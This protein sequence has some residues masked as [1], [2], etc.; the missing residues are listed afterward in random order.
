MTTK[1][2]LRPAI[3]QAWLAIN[4]ELNLLSE[5]QMIQQKD[6]AGWCVK[7]H[8]VHMMAWER[9]MVYFLQGKQRHAGLGVDEAVYLSGDEDRINHAIFTR[10]AHMPLAD[11]L[12]QFRTTHAELMA[13]VEP[14]SDAEL[15]M[16]YR[17]FLP[18]EPG[19]G[20]GP[21][22]INLIYGNTAHHF[23]QHMRWI[24]SLVVTE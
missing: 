1:A 13:L 12:G 15:Q 10:H 23:Q 6:E 19:E 9:A 5:S 8:L 24:A 2:E 4:R 17:H 3:E 14:M 20:D 22:A 18:D 21:L 11:V 7:D 16:P